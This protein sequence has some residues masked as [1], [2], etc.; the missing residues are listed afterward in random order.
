MSTKFKLA[1]VFAALLFFFSVTGRNTCGMSRSILGL[2]C[3][4]QRRLGQLQAFP[5]LLSPQQRASDCRIQAF[6]NTPL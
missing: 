1:A 4:G 6:Q 5:K 3:L 2:I